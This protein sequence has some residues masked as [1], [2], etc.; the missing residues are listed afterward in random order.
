MSR[1]KAVRWLGKAF[2]GTFSCFHL[3]ACLAGDCQR[4]KRTN[5]NR[6]SG[7]AKATTRQGRP[8]EMIK[9]FHRAGKGGEVFRQDQ[10]DQQGDSYQNLRVAF[11]V[12]C[13]RCA[14]AF[15]LIASSL[16]YRSLIPGKP[17]L[18]YLSALNGFDSVFL[19]KGTLVLTQLVNLGSHLVY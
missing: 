11:T 2:L 1:G 5:L 12:S 17:Y 10:H 6:Q 13:I 18:F 16:L 15:A 7:F 9:R 4:T 19:S 8:S 14:A 3:F